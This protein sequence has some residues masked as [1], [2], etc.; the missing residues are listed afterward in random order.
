MTL[1]HCESE[2]WYGHLSEYWAQGKCWW[3]TNWHETFKWEKTWRKKL[4]KNKNLINYK[5]AIQVNNEL[6]LNFDEQQDKEKIKRA[7][8]NI[9]YRISMK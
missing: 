6:M 8:S 7:M 1:S 3:S 2:L 4:V 9:F 5:R